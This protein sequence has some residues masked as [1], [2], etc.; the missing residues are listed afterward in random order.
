MVVKSCLT[1]LRGAPD[2]M[3]IP[4]N[5]LPCSQ[6]QLLSLTIYWPVWTSPNMIVYPNSS[7]L[8]TKPTGGSILLIWRL[9]HWSSQILPSTFWILQQNQ[10]QLRITFS[11]LSGLVWNTRPHL[12]DG[13]LP[14]KQK[15]Q[16][17]I[18]RQELH[19]RYFFNFSC[20]FLN[21]NIFFQYEF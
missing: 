14:K 13:P 5:K 1:A 19:S 18:Q 3:S 4:F 21:L 2:Q 6:T 15:S 16:K 20:M 7:W 17:W 10:I 12:V 8:C 11:K 9:I